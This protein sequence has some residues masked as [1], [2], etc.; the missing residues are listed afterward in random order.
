MR[1]VS[2]IVLVFEKNGPDFLTI[3]KQRGFLAA[4]QDVVALA[5]LM[6]AKLELLPE[7]RSVCW[8]A[9]A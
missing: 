2:G 8:S 7:R 9:I 1:I 6:L 4:L 5:R 3:G